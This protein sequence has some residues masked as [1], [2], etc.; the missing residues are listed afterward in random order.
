[1]DPVSVAASVVG[2]L[3]AGAQL[4]GLL[5][6]F[7]K[8]ANGAPKAAHN[9][10]SEVADISACLWKLQ[11]FLLGIETAPASRTFLMMIEHIVVTLT[12][13]VTTF[14]ELGG[15]LDAYSKVQPWSALDRYKWTRR[16]KTITQLLQRLQASKASLHFMLTTLTW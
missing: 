6:A 13:T 5:T 14:S 2:L 16:E 15:T 1:M 8:S 10:L 11:S 9:V 3:G 12:S 4:L 7:I